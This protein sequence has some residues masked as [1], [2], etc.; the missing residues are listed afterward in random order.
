MQQSRSS[1]EVEISVSLLDNLF[2]G[3]FE[4]LGKDHIT[5]LANSLHTCFLSD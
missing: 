4:I 3:L 5:I 2:V 1:V